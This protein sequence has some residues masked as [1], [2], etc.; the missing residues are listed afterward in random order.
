[1]C[2]Q[3]TETIS[4]NDISN[5]HRC[6][7]KRQLHIICICIMYMYIIHYIGIRYIRSTMGLQQS[8]V[9]LYRL[10]LYPKRIYEKIIGRYLHVLYARRVYAYN[11]IIYYII[12]RRCIRRRLGF[13]FEF[14]RRRLNLFSIFIRGCVCFVFFFCF[15]RRVS[16]YI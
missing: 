5:Y 16:P 7:K 10:Y 3:A 15:P 1:M 6:K 9:S 14:R 12:A 11:N 4:L 2:A 8:S 13:R